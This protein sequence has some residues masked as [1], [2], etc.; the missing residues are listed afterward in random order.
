MMSG[1]RDPTPFE[2]G[3]Y[4]DAIASKDAKR[5][6]TIVSDMYPNVMWGSITRGLSAEDQKWVMDNLTPEPVDDDDGGW[7]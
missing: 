1:P 7:G 2:T 3:M 5:L 6:R 4:Q